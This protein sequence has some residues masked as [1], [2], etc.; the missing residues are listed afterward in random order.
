M[1]YISLNTIIEKYPLIMKYAFLIAKY[2]LCMKY[3]SMNITK[4]MTF[5]LITLNNIINNYNG[6][7]IIAKKSYIY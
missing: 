6:S 3:I 5:Q 1:C 2:L 4:D 7:D